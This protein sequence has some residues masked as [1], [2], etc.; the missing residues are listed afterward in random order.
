MLRLCTTPFWEHHVLNS[1]YPYV[2]KC[3]R[4][5]VLQW[6]P[7]S[8]FWIAVPLWLYM[9][10]KRK[11]QPRAL[12]ISTLFMVKTILTGLFILIQIS[13]ISYSAI[14]LNE[15]TLYAIL[16]A[17]FFYLITSLFT[18][19]TM[20]YDRLKGMFSS[21]LLC[22]FWLLVTLTSLPDVIDYSVVFS[23]QIK[24]FRYVTLYIE[25]SIILFH[26]LFA[27]SLFIAN[28][29]AE[30]HSFVK[31][32]T[33]EQPV[34]LE[35]YVSLP[36][37]LFFEWVTPLILQGYRKPLTEKDCWQLPA[38][39]QTVTV[40][41]QVQKTLDSQI[42]QIPK[43]TNGYLQSNE[44]KD[45]NENLLTDQPE[46]HVKKPSSKHQRPLVLWRALF[47]TY[48]HRLIAG[49]LLRV[50][51]NC[52]LFVGPFMLKQLLN[53]FADPTKP[54]WLGIFYALVLSAAVFC[55]ILVLRAYFQNQ[56]IVGLRFRSAITGLVYRKSLRLSNSAKQQ[57]TTGEIVNLMA[58]DASRFAEV[59]HHIHVLW[60]GP[61][62]LIFAFIFLYRQMQW[63]II[64]GVLLLIIMI[65]TNSY[66]QRIQKR[67]TTK[68][69]L[70]KDQRIKT[71]NE[72][73][74]GIRVLKLYAWEVAFM[75][76]ILHIREKEL[77][78]IRLK[79]INSATIS[80]LATFTPILVG[81]LTFATYVLSSDKNIL[82][83]DKAFV[84]LALFN[85]LRGPLN[86]FPNVISSVVE[87]RVANARIQKFLNHQELDEAVVDKVPLGLDKN[88][89]KIER[90]SFR[91]SDNVEDPLI[92]KDINVQIRQGSLVA[93]VGS[94]G[95]G[96]SSLLA[97]LLGEM[98]KARGYVSI[99]GLI[100]YVPQTAWIMN[101]TLK[102]NI[103]FGRDYDKQLYDKIIEACALKHDLD[104][105][106]AGDRTE[107]GEKGINL[108][109]GQRQRVSLARALY[110]NAD[111]YLLDDPLSAVDAHV[112]AHIFRQVIGRKGL[113]RDKTRLLVT[114]GVSH[115]HKCDS[116]MVINDGEIADQG[117]YNELI[118]RSKT[119]RDFIHSTAISDSD[120]FVRR[121]SETESIRS[122]PSVPQELIEN[123]SGE[124]EE[125][126]QI[127]SVE[128]P[129]EETKIIQK[130]TIQTGSVKLNVF[131]AYIRANR[132]PMV[133][134]ILML[135]SMTICAAFSANVWMSRWTDEAKSRKASNNQIRNMVIYS[136]LGATQGIFAFSMQM[137]QKLA[138]F[139]AGRRL[140]WIIL[141]GILRA[142]MSFFDTTPLGRIINRFA[143]D[144]DAVDGTLPSSIS[145][146]LTTLITVI[147][148]ITIL[149]Y[150]SWFAII[151][152]IPLAL[153]FAFIQRVYVSSSRQLRRLDSVTRS[154]I[155]ANFSETIQGLTSIRAYHEQQR[156]ID[157]SDQ[158]TDRN[159]SCH[160]AS[161][162]C[163]RWLAVRLEM[164]GNL[165][166]L[167]TA[168][169]AVFVRD[170]L[171]AGTV[172]LMIT[173]AM[174]INQALNLLIRNTSEIE[175]NIVSVERIHEYAE[176]T[177][178]APWEIPERKPPVHWPTN[179]N[180]LISELS[181]RYRENL[182]LVLKNLTL[183]IRSGEKIGIIGRTGSGK[184]SLCLALFRIIE[185]T[186]G[187]III[188]DVDIR[189]IGIHDL[190]SKITIIPQDAVIFAGTVRFNVD[191][192][193][194][195]SDMEI[196]S[197]L[198]LV[199]LK[200]RICTADNGLSY[201]L[202]EGGQNISAGEKQL[203]CLAR[204]L[205][206]KSKI[207]ILDEA[208]AAIDM[209]T[210]RLIQ[211]TIRSVFKDAT[212]LTIAHRLHTILDSS[213]ILVLA[214]GTIEE[215]DEPH[216]LAADPNSI[217]SKL[218][219]SANI[220][221]LDIG[222]KIDN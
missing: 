97:A 6:I 22:I 69:M 155:F 161:S 88:S 140:H 23:Q 132:L 125:E 29:F 197:A 38:S 24:H 111:I 190:R 56:F 211:L 145:Q 113:M 78:Y 173:Y 80:M 156:F 149:I 187:T 52:T 137:I 54:K 103:L 2:P 183:D 28:C 218:L 170:H 91:W 85:L 123:H 76:S 177:P 104:V 116:I 110:S 60:S 51:E 219:Q 141:V 166:T 127:V 27:L 87:A 207:F 126:E 169:T 148:T 99:S 37:K 130:E 120:E 144:I 131:S 47:R 98:N 192:F 210:D 160:L 139:A 201:L 36:S 17:S 105:L 65:P 209:E 159:S 136:I 32:T 16:L 31:S 115:L 74:N 109:G 128:I 19:W 95:A 193:G 1:T 174:Q 35:S 12:K 77:K 117:S 164:I 79:A 112:G 172:G 129:E 189:F 49:G 73:L 179:G 4:H 178:E 215:F 15:P 108:S 71:M 14:K 94:V 72:I 124:H 180:I 195:Y 92:L 13:R 185:P 84:S 138:A 133:G 63:A 41:R 114:H 186:N 182:Q 102:D 10:P 206:R 67:L 58:I 142:P 107:I 118:R 66:L 162:I 11:S 152:L 220:S 8:I 96:K 75:R 135:F 163:N 198:E 143:K 93:I 168:I 151:E 83:A 217:F 222:P 188:D 208:T 39:E 205:L 213:R 64:P 34:F 61:F 59:T 199:N 33:D 200:E 86:S 82:T 21:G 89:V 20:N 7:I 153:L 167:L 48:R 18:L 181:T 157:L 176:L 25:L 50:F 122:L 70:V 154:S 9:L 57:T 101:T 146:V 196:W 214:N 43:Y 147:V 90:G 194:N 62:Q 150:G 3:F 158:F 40:V 203:L 81:V 119:L 55:Q 46:V 175:A 26:F 184:S 165:L 191:P 106:P 221:P 204:A 42:P 100:A 134:L 68:Q 5:T 44:I 216:K 202:A 212:V 53:F 171:S 45:E 30:K 121:A